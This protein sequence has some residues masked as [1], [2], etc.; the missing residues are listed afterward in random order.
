MPSMTRDV[1]CG[2]ELQP[3]VVMPYA[4]AKSD[5]GPAK[6]FGP[7]CYVQQEA[8]NGES[9]QVDSKLAPRKSRDFMKPHQYGWVGN[10]KQHREE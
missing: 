8:Q 9:D 2:Q 5:H 1:R 10:E 6:T 4:M 3:S 7:P